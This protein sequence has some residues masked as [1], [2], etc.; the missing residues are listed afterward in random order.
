LSLWLLALGTAAAADWRLVDE[1]GG[2][3]VFVDD[4]QDTYNGKATC[5]WTDVPA[6]KVIGALEDPGH[7]PNFFT[8]VTESRVIARDGN[9][10]KVFQ[11]HKFPIGSDRETYKDLTNVDLGNG[12]RIEWKL[13][14]SPP[15]PTEGRVTLEVDSGHWQIEQ[16]TGGTE[17]EFFMVYAP[18]GFLGVFPAD[19]FMAE[20]MVKTLDELRAEAS[21]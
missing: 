16:G 8:N 3:K 18:G 13:F 17:I 6:A 11:V 4:S 12:L 5:L 7:A 9:H 2:C 21:K 1:T 20:G 15:P 10:L 14:A 19:K